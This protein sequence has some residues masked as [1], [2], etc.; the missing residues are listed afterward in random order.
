MR[1]AVNAIAAFTAMQDIY[2]APQTPQ[3][4]VA[5]VLAAAWWT[6][7]IEAN[8]ATVTL[9]K[10]ARQFL[11]T[12]GTE[13]VASGGG[14]YAT[15]TQTGSRT[16]FENLCSGIGADAPYAASRGWD[17]SAMAFTVTNAG[18]DARNVT[19]GGGYAASHTDPNGKTTSF[20]FTPAQTASATQ[21]PLPYGLLYQVFTANSATLANLAYAY[22]GT[23]RINTIAD[24]DS[25]QLG[26]RSP[27]SF[28]IADGARGER[29]DPLGAPY[30]V[31]YDTF[32][33]ASRYIDELGRETDATTD[34]R[35]RAQSYTYP[36]LDQEV[37]TYDERNNPLSLTRKAKPG[38]GLADLAVSV[39]YTEAATVAICSSP[40]TCN[41]PVTQTN[42]RAQVTNIAWDPTTGQ[43]T[44][45]KL[46]ADPNGQRP[47]TDYGYTAF[48][49]GFKLLTSKTD[50]IDSTHSLVTNFAWNA[51]NA[52]VPQS[53]AVDCGT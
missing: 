49:S 13:W 17:A 9:G 47:E 46:P 11:N 7:R 39:S 40:Q 8:V 23:N 16:Q 32:G 20:T 30:T 29:D 24:A 35:G 50:K 43:L 15:L 37:L 31:V 18:G 53:T 48:G 44:Q 38:S 26:G 51:A 3:R 33:H 21:R 1:G 22:D 19:G 34:G 2:K 45:T 41:K 14:S 25:I 28:F 5:G 52:Y 27:Y 42:A 12:A 36:E 4:D 10:S 6:H